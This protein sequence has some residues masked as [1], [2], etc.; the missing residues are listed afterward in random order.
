MILFSVEKLCLIQFRSYCLLSAIAGFLRPEP[1]SCLRSTSLRSFIMGKLNCSPC[2]DA[3]VYNQ[4][5][6]FSPTAGCSCGKLLQT[7]PGQAFD[8]SPPGN[9]L[10]KWPVSL[11]RYSYFRALSLMFIQ[12]ITGLMST[13][14]LLDCLTTIQQCT[15]SLAGTLK[16]YLRSLSQIGAF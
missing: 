2:Q 1:A 7:A 11:W 16:H 12:C 5:L 3:T 4:P 6:V 10:A 14:L 15:P 9:L 8:L 13:C